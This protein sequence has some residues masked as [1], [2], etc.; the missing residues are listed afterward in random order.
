MSEVKLKICGV[1]SSEEMHVLDA[2]PI[3]FIGLNFIETSKR[4]VNY[5]AAKTILEVKRRESLVKTVALFRDHP[6][7]LVRNYAE[8]L[9]FDFVQL[10]G[11]EDQEYI[12]MLPV[13]VLR[14]IYVGASDTAQSI[15]DEINSV[16]TAY[17]ILDRQTQGRGPLVDT[18][19]ASEVVAILPDRIFLAGGINPDN[20]HRILNEVSP[21]AID[22]SGGVHSGDSIDLQKISA[23]LNAIKNTQN[24]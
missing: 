12:K 20:I 23:C 17:Y 14:T 6:I 10:N 22:I 9:H 15:L 8:S 13:S 3:D 18:M 21:F 4:Y 5:E 1:T 19:L 11:S 24:Y 2:L 7:D 16:H